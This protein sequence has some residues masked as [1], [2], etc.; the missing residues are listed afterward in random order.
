MRISKDQLR[1]I[2]QE[3]LAQALKEDGPSLARGQTE[4]SDAT[5]E[6]MRN[7]ELQQIQHKLDVEAGL[8]P[9]DAYSGEPTE[10]GAGTGQSVASTEGEGKS[11]KTVCT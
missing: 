11:C 2:I 1:Q 7:L 10:G 3:E 6:R 4:W 5:K 9:P 8:V